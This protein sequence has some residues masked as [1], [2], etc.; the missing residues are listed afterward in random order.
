MKTKKINKTKVRSIIYDIDGK[1]CVVDYELADMYGYSY[2]D[3][4][5]I[6]QKHL[7]L[8]NND[9]RF[10]ITEDELTEL[11][12]S[13]KLKMQ[14][15][16]DEEGHVVLPYVYTEPG[17]YLLISVLKENLDSNITK[18]F[19]DVFYDINEEIAKTS[20]FVRLEQLQKVSE[21]IEDILNRLEK[22][23]GDIN[24]SQNKIK[25]ISTDNNN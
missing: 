24:S 10:K 6:M 2:D 8:F 9:F 22:I 16:L 21:R 7:F 4:N 11:V 19:L 1:K 15:M 17:Y 3:F 13:G 5:N 25:F 20:Y 14:P 18:A 23:V 12:S